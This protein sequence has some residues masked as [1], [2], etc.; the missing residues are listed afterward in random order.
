[1]RLLELQHRIANLFA[2][3]FIEIEGHKALGHTDINRVAE[4]VLIPVFRE[5][6][7][8]QNLKNLNHHVKNNYPAIDL[9]DETAKI[10]IQVTATSDGE[11]IKETLSGFIKHEHY[12]TY[13][14]VQIYILTKK[15]SYERSEKVFQKITQ[16]KIQFDKKQDILDY[17]DLLKQIST[18]QVEQVQRICNILEANFGNGK[19]SSEW[20]R[21]KTKSHIDVLKNKLDSS[22]AWCVERFAAAILDLEEADKLADDLQRFAVK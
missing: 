19:K 18:F 9:G 16:G 12:Q 1:M 20:E 2:T 4:N 22:R 7:G 17:T 6:Y 14:R 15:E 3:S 5:V 13:K 10:A 11:K 21:T 8:Y